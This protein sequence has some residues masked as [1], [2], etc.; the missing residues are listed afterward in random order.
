MRGMIYMLILGTAASAGI[1]VD[2]MAVIVGKHVIKLSDVD[3]D[4]RLTAFLNREP[5]KITPETKRQ[6][7]ERLIDQEIIRQ[8]IVTGAF[9]RPSESDAA[10]LGGQLR[11]ERFGGSETRLR[12]ELRRYGLT[13][14]ELRA[15]LLWNLTVLNFID[16]RFR[17]GTLVTDEEVRAYYDQ[18]LAELRREYPKDGG[19]ETLAPKI[20]SSLE[21]QRVDQNFNNWLAQARKRYRTEYKQEAFG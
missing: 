19:F 21:G 16:Q 6:S 4:L 2:R 17:E 1:V 18:H 7:A 15:Q 8:E 10:G 5:L 9:R 13:E 3:R 20:R 11:Q 12:E 14:D